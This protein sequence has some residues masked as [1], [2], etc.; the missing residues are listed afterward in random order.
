[1]S[2]TKKDLNQISFVRSKREGR[3]GSIGE[4]KGVRVRR[5]GNGNMRGWERKKSEV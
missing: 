5:D 1:M 3:R 4:Q 2:E